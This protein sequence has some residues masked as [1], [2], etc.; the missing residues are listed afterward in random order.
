[1]SSHNQKK[2]LC[3]HWEIMLSLAQQ[4]RVML[5]SGSEVIGVGTTK[6]QKSCLLVVVAQKRCLP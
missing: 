5:A 3:Q 1:V 6:K 2:G 4:K